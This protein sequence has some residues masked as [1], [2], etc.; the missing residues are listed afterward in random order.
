MPNYCSILKIFVS[1][2]GSSSVC[3]KCVRK[4]VNCY[5]LFGE[6]EKA[7]AVGCAVEETKESAS[8]T[9]T[10]VERK[11]FIITC[12]VLANSSQPGPA[13]IWNASKQHVHGNF[14]FGP[15]KAN[16]WRRKSTSCNRNE[17]KQCINTWQ[18]TEVSNSVYE[19]ITV[20][21]R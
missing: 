14:I 17:P 1:H 12:S 15:S 13:S 20:S 9:P 10:R 7:F 11:I 2:Y 5:K 19:T 16:S 21:Y 3:K 18:I 4:I 8:R 6:L